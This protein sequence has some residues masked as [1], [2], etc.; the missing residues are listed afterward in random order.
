MKISAIIPAYNEAERIG[1]VIQPLLD[2]AL[3]DE[4]IV[5]DDGSTDNTAEKAEEFA[6][7]VI[8]LP[9]NKGKAVAMDEGVKATQNDTLLFLDADL[10]GLTTAHIDNLIRKYHEENVD[11]VIGIFSAGR[12]TSLSGQRV[13]SKALWQRARSN[14]NELDFGIEIALTKLA[15]K[16]KWTKSTIKLPGV[17]HVVKEEKHGFQQGLGARVKMY[18]D[19]IKSLFTKV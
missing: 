8:S 10:V 1:A 18:G 3:I 9:D 16:E 15:F 14:V 13:I 11:M 4:I 7:K 5:V 6:V 2:S 12:L 19:I 17:T